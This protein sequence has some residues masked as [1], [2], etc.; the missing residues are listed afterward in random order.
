MGVSPSLLP[1]W[2]WRGEPQQRSSRMRT[3]LRI[4]RKECTISI[5]WHR[6]SHPNEAASVVGNSVRGQLS[7]LFLSHALLQEMSILWQVPEILDPL[8]HHHARCLH[9]C[10]SG[11]QRRS[12]CCRRRR[13]TTN[14]SPCSPKNLFRSEHPVYRTN[15]PCKLSSLCF[16]PPL[17]F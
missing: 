9:C 1:G 3:S 11:Q 2:R 15:R 7:S 12:S 16:S 5:A 10:T 14:R 13:T 8:N 4:L 17:G 6:S